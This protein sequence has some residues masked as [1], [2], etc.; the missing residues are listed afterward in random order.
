MNNVHI[1]AIGAHCG[2]ME[3]TAGGVIAKYTKYGNKA[4][5]VHMTLGEKGHPTLSPEEY[6]RQK[7]EEAKGVAKLLGANVIFLDYK[8]GE[9]PQN[10]EIEFQICDLIRREKPDICV[11]HWRNS[12][13]P[14]H[15]NTYRNVLGGVFKAS[16]KAIGREYTA[17]RVKKLLFAENWEDSGDF[18]PYI[19]IDI[20]EVFDQWIEAISKYELFR[21]GVSNFPYLDYYKSLAKIRGAESGFKYAEAFDVLKESKKIFAQFF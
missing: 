4:T 18:E 20:S 6:G 10:E 14:D 7:I 5:I 9:L 21:G 1:M 15:S 17:H 16:L 12:I 3:V 8:D 2:D 19:Y 11:T 13:H